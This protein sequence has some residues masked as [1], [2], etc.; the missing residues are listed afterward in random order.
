MSVLQEQ[1]EKFY[2]LFAASTKTPELQYNLSNCLQKIEALGKP[3]PGVFSASNVPNGMKGLKT[4]TSNRLKKLFGSMQIG[5]S[6]LMV[7]TNVVRTAIVTDL[8]LALAKTSAS[9]P[10][11]YLTERFDEDGSLAAGEVFDSLDAEIEQ[12]S[13]ENA[14]AYPL[15]DSLLTLENEGIFRLILDFLLGPWVFSTQFDDAIKLQ[16]SCIYNPLEFAGIAASQAGG[17]EIVKMDFKRVVAYFFT[18]AFILSE[19]KLR[20]KSPRQFR[21][22]IVAQLLSHQKEEL[23]VQRILNLRLRGARGGQSLLSGSDVMCHYK[24]SFIDIEMELTEPSLRA[25]EELVAYSPSETIVCVKEGVA[26]ME[27]DNLDFGELLKNE[28]GLPII[29]AR[30]KENLSA[31]SDACATLTKEVG[32]LSSCHYETLVRNVFCAQNLI[33]MQDLGKASWRDFANE[34]LKVLNKTAT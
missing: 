3:V 2:G 29:G 13:I 21:A 25:H 20:E 10:V 30:T 33:A 15:G 12:F 4:I 16:T 6:V 24:S 17:A 7:P 27:R 14:A 5:Q 11:L 32:P 9:E 22:E 1:T 18:E 19:A 8:W 34:L 28:T 26:I 23:N 31:F